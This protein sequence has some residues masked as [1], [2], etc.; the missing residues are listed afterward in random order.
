M[1]RCERHVSSRTHSIVYKMNCHKE[2]GKQQAPDVLNNSCRIHTV[3]NNNNCTA[4]RSVRQTHTIHAVLTKTTHV[5]TQLE[6]IL[7]TLKH[8]LKT[9]RV[10]TGK[11]S[12]QSRESPYSSSAL[13]TACSTTIQTVKVG[14][15]L[16]PR[17]RFSMYCRCIRRCLPS[18]PWSVTCGLGRVDCVLFVERSLFHQS[19]H[20]EYT[21]STWTHALFDFLS[22]ALDCASALGRIRRLRALHLLMAARPTSIVLTTAPPAPALP[23]ELGDRISRTCYSRLRVLH[24]FQ[25]TPILELV[26]VRVDRFAPNCS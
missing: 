14:D 20:T 6:R 26:A 23:H 7:E 13:G 11:Y 15:Q 9:S 10:A 21:Q 19:V 24:S 1:S 5:W 16:L 3:L 22:R 4:P 18:K 2:R 12:Y 25:V 8:S 17:C